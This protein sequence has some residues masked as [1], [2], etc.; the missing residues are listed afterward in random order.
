[1]RFYEIFNMFGNKKHEYNID[2]S[3]SKFYGDDDE[4]GENDLGRD[5]VKI[6]VAKFDNAWKRSAGALYIGP[7]GVGSIKTRYADFGKW[8]STANEPINDS[9]VGVDDHGDIS[10]YNGRHRFA[11]LRDS[12]A[13]DIMVSMDPYS[14]RNA[15]KFGYLK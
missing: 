9:T 1:M 11:Y 2:P 4:D 8:L 3:F 14:F 13:K 15:K 10:F 12:G 5:L 6:N 7:N